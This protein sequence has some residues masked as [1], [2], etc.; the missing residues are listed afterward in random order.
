[1]VSDSNFIHQ[2]SFFFIKNHNK[3]YGSIGGEYMY[4]SGGRVE[5]GRMKMRK[6]R[7]ASMGMMLICE[8][9][10]LSSVKANICAF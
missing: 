6:S 1:M 8:S 7:L 5:G 9:I 10:S 3:S 2:S 4:Y